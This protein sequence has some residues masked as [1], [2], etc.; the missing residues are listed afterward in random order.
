LCQSLGKATLSEN[1]GYDPT[2]QHSGV[3]CY[4]VER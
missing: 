1:T 3:K 2:C 4:F